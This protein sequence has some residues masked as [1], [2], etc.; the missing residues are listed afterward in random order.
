M[1]WRP[2]SDRWMFSG[3]SQAGRAC[4]AGPRAQARSHN[5]YAP[6]GAIS[7]RKYFST[8]DVRFQRIERAN[9]FFRHGQNILRED[10]EIRQFVRLDGS[11]HILFKCQ[12]SII[13][14]RNA[15][16]LFAANFLCWSKYGSIFSF[17]GDVKVKRDEG[18][19]RRARPVTA[20]SDNQMTVEHVADGNRSISFLLP[21]GFDHVV[22]PAISLEISGND[23]AEP[24]HSVELV[25]TYNW[26]VFKNPALVTDG[27]LAVGGLV[28]VQRLIDIFIS[29]SDVG[30]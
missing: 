9:L 17:A 25:R 23:D 21:V 7:L 10:Q 14:C 3:S 1:I 26:N 18:I 22:R 12:V 30:R 20:G 16:S 19:V 2:A 29:T 6:H 28:R 15:Q 13:D 5:D 11:L 27:L 24:S 8:A 4:K